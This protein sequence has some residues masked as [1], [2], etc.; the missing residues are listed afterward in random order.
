MFPSDTRELVKLSVAVVVSA[1]TARYLWSRFLRR[2]SC[3]GS[4][5]KAKGSAPNKDG[6]GDQST[7]GAPA[8]DCGVWIYFGSQSG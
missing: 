4:D 7:S 5:A 3:E 6:L 8:P 1:A 2:D